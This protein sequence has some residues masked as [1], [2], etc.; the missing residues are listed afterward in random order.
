MKPDR[1]TKQAVEQCAER[2]AP[3]RRYAI[4]VEQ[5]SRESAKHGRVLC[6]YNFSHNGLWQRNHYA[7]KQVAPVIKG[8]P[9][10]TVV[11]TV[12]TFFF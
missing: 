7:I 12:Y 8:E 4:I 9:E 11:I 3:R 10:E 5:G 2:G 6:R 1:L